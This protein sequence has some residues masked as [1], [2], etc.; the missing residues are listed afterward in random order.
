MVE[1]NKMF[2]MLPLILASRYIDGEDPK[3]ILYLRIAYFSVQFVIVLFT[4]YTYIQATVAAQGK[5][6]KVIYVP[7]AAQVRECSV[8]FDTHLSASQVETYVIGTTRDEEAMDEASHTRSFS[9]KQPF[10]DPNAKKKYTETTF[11]AHLL[12]QAR[13]LLGS[14]LFGI[15][16]TSGLHYYR[17]MVVG[18][19]IQSI[20]GP[21]TLVENPIVKSLLF[22]KGMREQDKIFQEKTAA[23]LTPEDEVVDASGNP[24]VRTLEGAATKA[25]GSNKGN[26]TFEE[27][28]LDTWDAGAKADLGPL[29]AIIDKENCNY[30]TKE[31]G[32]TPLMILSG[33][34][35]VKGNESAIRHIL[36]LGGNPA[37]TD[38]EGWNAMHWAAFHGSIEAATILGSEGK[39]WVA[40]DKEGKTALVLA[41]AEGNADVAKLLEELEAEST[42]SKEPKKDR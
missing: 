21:L 24:I 23:D 35:G 22:G 20:M 5:E 28:L 14:T 1:F 18:L 31:N 40:A 11:G 12:S 33:L 10:A 42:A 6:D 34:G 3:V 32:W 7:P 9:H 17:G 16:L 38:V 8:L 19:A 2:V 39:L 37:V 36:T 29:M 13:N 27:V 4:I 15:C 30:K 26:G 41:K 25:T